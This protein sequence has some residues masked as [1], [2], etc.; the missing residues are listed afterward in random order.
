MPT[1]NEDEVMEFEIVDTDS[2]K[3]KT[4]VQPGTTGATMMTFGNGMVKVPNFIMSNIKN[5]TNAT[6][7][8]NTFQNL[9]TT[10]NAQKMIPFISKQSLNAVRIL[11][12][13]KTL[14]TSQTTSSSTTSTPTSGLKC[15]TIK[16]ETNAPQV[17]SPQWLNSP[18]KKY[19]A[20]KRVS[21]SPSPSKVQNV[22]DHAYVSKYQSPIITMKRLN[23]QQNKSKPSKV[24]ERTCR[25]CLQ[26]KEKLTPL[27]CG[28]HAKPQFNIFLKECCSIE[29]TLEDPMPKSVCDDCT[30]K[31]QS[32]WDFRN[33]CQKS[34]NEL[35]KFY[36]LPQKNYSQ[37]REDNF[38]EKIEKGV[39]VESYDRMKRKEIRELSKRP[40][41]QEIEE[42]M[43][44]MNE[45]FDQFQEQVLQEHPEELL[46]EALQE[47]QNRALKVDFHDDDDDNVDEEEDEDND[48]KEKE[49][50]EK[51][52]DEK[53]D[54]N[55]EN[56][57]SYFFESFAQEISNDVDN[58]D[59]EQ[60]EH[61]DPQE[62]VEI[63]EDIS[64]AAPEIDE[65]PEQSETTKK[66]TVKRKKK[67]SNDEKEKYLCHMCPRVFTSKAFLE[68]HSNFHLAEKNHTCETC[69][70]VFKSEE[71]LKTH[72]R[73]HDKTKRFECEVCGLKYVYEYL[74]NSHLRLHGKGKPLSTEKHFLCE[75][76]SKT[77]ASQSGLKHHQKL[78]MD[79][80][81]YKCRF[82]EKTF[83]MPIYRKKHELRHSETRRYSCHLCP[84]T[85]HSTNGLTN[86]LLLHTG[87]AH[88]HCKTCG[89]SFRRR[90][91]LNEHM[92]T[93]TG[94]KPY[95]CKMCGIGYGNSGSLFAHQK[96]CRAQFTEEVTRNIVEEVVEAETM[97]EEYFEGEDEEEEQEEEEQ[98]EEQII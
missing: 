43:E 83:T 93:H 82:C 11:Q 36:K 46:I 5:M 92:F 23:V 61:L 12:S 77:F 21:A 41:K 80:K 42:A 2:I 78:H 68:R 38:I 19:V 10:S 47:E 14:S 35:R 86:H 75:V 57:V 66:R 60:Q 72:M 34:D 51:I 9:A 18:M 64:D 58:S 62:L 97:I 25:L 33:L 98:E 55:E 84:A 76:C 22:E 65:N 94:E 39:Q 4:N 26:M 45:S 96:R 67:Q 88:Y 27:I 63:K 56:P 6:K 13:P 31:L 24:A 50:I 79:L 48:I 52:E 37:L 71:K 15:V 89:K 32:A 44:D 3:M 53:T 16:Q 17:E 95:I 90:K 70:K 81:P 49:E 20:K 87:E 73:I 7:V 8:P 85:Y 40:I 54:D 59:A 28:N 74:L 29:V 1:L 69:S 91:Y 30:I